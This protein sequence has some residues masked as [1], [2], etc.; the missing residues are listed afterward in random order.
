MRNPIRTVQDLT[1]FQVNRKD[2][3]EVVR[4]TFYD[5]NVAAAAGQSVLTFF[6]VQQGQGTPAK[7]LAQTNMQASGSLPAPLR[8]LV[9]AIEVYFFP[10]VLPAVGPVAAAI[11]NFVND[12]WKFLTGGAGA[13]VFNTPFLQFF[14]GSKPYLNEGISLMRFPPFGRLDGFAGE[15]DATTAA[16]A[17]YSRSS[18]ITAAGRP[19]IMDPPLLLEPTQN[20]NVTFNW[21]T[22]VS[23][24][25]VAG[26]TA[27]VLNGVLV[28][29]SQ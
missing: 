23:P 18:Y 4:Q 17:L 14:I 26:S 16:A 25:S 2:Q 19:Y 7:T 11:D 21:P 10:G 29:N 1:Q 5:T 22:A 8:F 27:C 15:T 12:T 9:Q 6:A 13:G 3:M 20:F 24:L 28:R